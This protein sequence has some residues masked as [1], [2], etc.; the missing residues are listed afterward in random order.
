VTFSDPSRGRRLITH[1][2]RSLRIAAGV[3]DFVTR[4]DANQAQERWTVAADGRIGR[5]VYKVPRAGR[6]A[7]A[8]GTPLGRVL[9][10]LVPAVLLG[11]AE[12]RRVWR[13]AR[14]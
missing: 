11:A 5:V 9:L 2:V 12:L 3:A 14:A 10:I 7:A 8:L 1:R 4:G 13:P 6:V